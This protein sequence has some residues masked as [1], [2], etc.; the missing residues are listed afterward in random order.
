MCACAW[1]FTMNGQKG[2]EMPQWLSSESE[3]T[4]DDELDAE[5]SLGDDLAVIVACV[6]F[7]AGW[8]YLMVAAYRDGA[9]LTLETA[10]LPVLIWCACCAGAGTGTM[11]ALRRMRRRRTKSH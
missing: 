10:A 4:E 6:L 9:A 3:L 7:L 11:R 5:T 8:T 1:G 2:G